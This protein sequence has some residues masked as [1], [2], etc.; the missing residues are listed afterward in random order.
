MW[1]QAYIFTPKVVARDTGT[2]RLQT[3]RYSIPDG[4]EIRFVRMLMS[5]DGLRYQGIN[6]ADKQKFVLGGC[7]WTEYDTFES[8]WTFW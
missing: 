8:F 1:F 6:F 2:S 4:R 5:K 7:Q 3:I